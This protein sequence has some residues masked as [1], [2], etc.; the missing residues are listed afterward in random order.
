[1]DL[2]VI[3]HGEVP[4]N[5]LGIISG[6]NNERLTE[7]GLRQAKEMAGKLE[8]VTFNRIYSSPVERSIQTANIVSKGKQIILDERL[9]ERDPGTMLGKSRKRIDKEVWNSLDIERTR[10]GG[11]TL[12]AELIRV[13]HFLKE[14]QIEDKDKTILVVTHNSISKCIW[15]LVNDISNKDEINDFFHDNGKIKK[16]V[17][18]GKKFK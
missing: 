4:S 1:M 12:K 9:T 6:R 15:M 18:D 10:E 13:R 2:Y 3:R 14:K 7:K 17:I 16:Y 11:E 8:N 5:L